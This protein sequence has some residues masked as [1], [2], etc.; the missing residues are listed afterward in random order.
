MGDDDSVP[1]GKSWVALY[2]AVN[3]SADDVCHI[4]CA[5]LVWDAAYQK[6]SEA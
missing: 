6:G 1:C 5:S 4:F 2:C 3:T